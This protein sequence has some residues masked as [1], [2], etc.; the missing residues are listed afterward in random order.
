MSKK[1]WFV[2]HPL[3]LYVE[4]VKTL[5]R[6]ADLKIVSSRFEPKNPNK[7]IVELNPPKLTLKSKVK[8][9]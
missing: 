3:S 7:D 9:K 1:V 8:A 4:D 5:A 2:K 6:K